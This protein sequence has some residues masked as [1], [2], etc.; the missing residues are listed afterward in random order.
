MA[1]EKVLVCGTNSQ[2]RIISE[3]PGFFL[4][5]L[6]SG[7]EIEYC[8]STNLFTNC[9]SNGPFKRAYYTGQ[10][11]EYDKVDCSEIGPTA[12]TKNIPEIIKRWLKEAGIPRIKQIN[13][14][15]L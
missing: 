15:Y 9:L 10:L 5:G 7:A 8:T 13:L 12:T 14:P 6:P 1:I 2:V 3:R 11:R 4:V